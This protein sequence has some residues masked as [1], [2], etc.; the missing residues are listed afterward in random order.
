MRKKII[1]LLVFI[2]VI[3][4]ALYKVL[5]YFKSK[6]IHLT[7]S[8]R[9]EADEIDLAARIP[10][11]IK[12]VMIED[13]MMVNKGDVIARID[14]ADL[15]S[16]RREAV[17]GIE[18]LKDKIRAAEIDFEY[19]ANNVE[20]SIDEAQKGLSVAEARLKQAE[21]KKENAEKE[22]NRYSSLLE[23]EVIPKEKYDNVDL[24]YKLSQED[25]RVASN[26][27]E[28]AKVSL[29]KAED[30]HKLVEAKEKELLSLKKSLTQ[31]QEKVRQ[32]DIYIGY[33]AITAPLD[34]V[35]LRKVAEPGEVLVEGGV[36]GVMIDPKDIH[37]KTY[38]PE[39]YIGK[40]RIGMDAKVISD[41]YPDQPFTGSICFISDKAEFT[42][43][44]VQSYEERIKQVF[45]VKICFPGK[46]S[47]TGEQKA[48]YDV[49]KKG[50]PVDVKFPFPPEK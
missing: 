6:D 48:Y 38:V 19:T 35:I 39:K 14:D 10:G 40:I 27:V 49:F 44:E 42:P 32:I 20:H 12:N 13:G 8:G 21:A 26:E 31:L 33:T 7:V 4:I 17:A 30:G 45:A 34:G 3:I 22:M 5:P 23:K 15:Q 29:M 1:I 24:A 28:K 9:A 50:M 46:G 25:V 16:Q 36:A 43:K 11:K 2:I 18:E 41:A 47:S 37:I